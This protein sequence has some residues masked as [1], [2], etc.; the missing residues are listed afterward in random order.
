[1]RCS[2][3]LAVV[4]VEEKV[5]GDDTR[6]DQVAVDLCLLFGEAS[7]LRNWSSPAS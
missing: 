5:G 4:G 1:M 7:I 3:H 6:N 2:A